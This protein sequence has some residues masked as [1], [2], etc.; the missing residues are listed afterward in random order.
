MPERGVPAAISAL[1]I[2]TAALAGVFGGLDQAALAQSSVRQGK[3]AFG[4]WQADKPG[5]LRLIKPRDLPAPGA[6]RSA[7][8]VSRVVPRPSGAVPQVPNGFK[9]ALFAEGLSGPRII[10]VAPNGDV[11]VAETEAGRIQVLRAAD[12]AASPSAKEVYASGLHEPFG[13]AFFPS[14]DNPQWIYVA[15]TDSVV[16]FSYHAGD[17][18]ASGKPETVVANLPH[19]YGHSTRDIAFTPDDKRMLVSVGSASNDGEDMGDP[20]SGLKAWASGKPLGAAWGSEADRAAVLAFDPD[21]KNR[22]LFATGIRNCVG[23]AIEPQSGTPWCSTNERDGLGDDL[24]PDYVTSVRENAFYGWPW[25]YIGNRE[26]PR[27]RR[28]RPDLKDRITMPDVLLQ[29]H[30]ASLGLTFYQGGNFPADYRGDAFAAEHGSWNR[31]KRTGYKIIRI[32]LKDGKPT[33]EYEDFVTGF[34]VNDREVWGRP[35]G[36]GVAHDGALLISEDANG[37]IWRVTAK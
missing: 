30:S 33:G 2:I 26:D 29:A 16:R 34:V 7:A 37:S 36:V 23:L 9:V 32:R 10:R 6:T 3:D 11:F 20:P 22:K 35:V 4:G 18:K 28:A 25:F 27:H 13:I 24:V 15:N 17:L 8:N 12:G 14:G 31:A 21:G 5:T 19:G 1:A